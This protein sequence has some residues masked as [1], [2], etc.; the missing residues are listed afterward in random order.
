MSKKNRLKIVVTY[1]CDR[2]DGEIWLRAAVRNSME[3]MQ[4]I[5]GINNLT[6]DIKFDDV[7]RSKKAKK[8][9]RKK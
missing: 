6:T 5:R 3:C 9:K 7:P 4:L 1:E 2:D 8:K